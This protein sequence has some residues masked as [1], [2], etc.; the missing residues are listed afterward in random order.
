MATHQDSGAQ[1]APMKGGF[2]PS[3]AAAYLG[4]SRSMVFRLLR[5]GQLPRRKVGSMTLL[6]REDLDQFLRSCPVEPPKAA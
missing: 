5:E 2:T 6:M 1:V 4:M 3:E